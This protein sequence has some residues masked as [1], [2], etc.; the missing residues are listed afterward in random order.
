MSIKDE[1][2]EMSSGVRKLLGKEEYDPG[3]RYIRCYHTS[4][5]HIYEETPYWTTHRCSTCGQY[6][7]VDS[8][9]TEIQV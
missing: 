6:Y 3:V 9:G 1:Y 5:G 7:D 2:D 4:D 8:N